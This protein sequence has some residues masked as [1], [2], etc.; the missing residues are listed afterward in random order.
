MFLFYCKM[1]RKRSNEIKLTVF[2]GEKSIKHLKE[3]KEDAN[4]NNQIE[5]A[6]LDVLQKINEESEFK[7]VENQAF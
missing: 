1:Q 4:A 3:R 6:V 2:G 5:A 7:Q